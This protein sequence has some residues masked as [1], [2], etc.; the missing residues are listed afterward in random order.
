MPVA[1]Y[2]APPFRR[3]ICVMDTIILDVEIQH[4][5][6]SPEYGW[7]ATDRLGV[8]VA[9]VYEYATRQFRVYGPDR[10]DA[11]RQRVAAAEQVIGF[12]TTDFDLPVILGISRAD[13]TASPHRAA[14]L[15][16]S[17][18][19][20]QHI[21]GTLG[22]KFQRGWNLDTVCGCTLGRHKTGN[23]AAAPLLFQAGRWGELVDYC[24]TDV[25]LTRDLYDFISTHGF[26]IGGVPERILRFKPRKST[27]MPAVA[28]ATPAAPAVDPSPA[29]V[30]SSP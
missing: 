28:P 5:P 15:P 4:D 1:R 20:L 10:L 16:R 30:A 18:D 23:G 13:W 6:T 27:T 11:L 9:A 7:D 29:S 22:T 21:W 14:F 3:K 26:C 2:R 17:H 12:N 19:I 25:A 8:S 24:L